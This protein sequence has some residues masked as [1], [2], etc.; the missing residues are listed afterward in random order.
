MPAKKKKNDGIRIQPPTEEGLLAYLVGTSSLLVNGMLPEAKEDLLNRALGIPA[1]R[2]TKKP[3]KEYT[4]EELAYAKCH[5]IGKDADGN[6]TYGF[7]GG[8]FQKLMSEVAATMGDTK[9]TKKLTNLGVKVPCDLVPLEYGKL[10]PRVDY[11]YAQ[12][13]NAAIAI[14]RAEFCYWTATLPLVLNTSSITRQ[15]ILNLL[16]QCGRV[17]IGAW[18]GIRSGHH[19]QFTIGKV[20][21]VDPVTIQSALAA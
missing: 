18:S 4:V 20:E 5:T 11:G 9:F 7:P 3:K 1:N 19:G 6:M 10:Q 13:A 15:E 2:A 14:V 8:G 21:V 12:K 17:G 16:D